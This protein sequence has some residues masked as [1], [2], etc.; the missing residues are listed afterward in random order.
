MAD[1][2]A[3]GS[4]APNTALLR[5]K[6]VGPGSRNSGAVVAQCRRPPRCRRKSTALRLAS[7]RMAAIFPTAAGMNFCPLKPGSTL[8]TST[9]SSASR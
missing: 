3:A 6:H 9:I 5:H 8:I 7:A 2:A 1:I 4:F